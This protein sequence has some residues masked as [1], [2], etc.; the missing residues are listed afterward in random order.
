MTKE[1]NYN[2][3]ELQDAGLT[4]VLADIQRLK[5]NSTVSTNRR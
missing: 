4:K 3:N 2:L 1:P 5:S